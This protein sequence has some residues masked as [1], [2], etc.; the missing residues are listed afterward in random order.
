MSPSY[1]S[2]KR[3]GTHFSA[4][5]KS[6]KRLKAHCHR[7]SPWLLSSADLS[8]WQRLRVECCRAEHDFQPETLDIWVGTRPKPHLTCMFPH[9]LA[10]AA[11]VE[12]QTFKALHSHAR[13]TWFTAKNISQSE[14][15]AADDGVKQLLW[16]MLVI[17]LGHKWSRL[18]GIE[19]VSGINHKTRVSKWN[20]RSNMPPTLFHKL[21]NKRNG[22]TP[23]PKCDKDESAFRYVW[24][25]TF[26]LH[27]RHLPD[28][29]IHN[30]LETCLW[31][32]F[33]RLWTEYY[34]SKKLFYLLPN[35]FSAPPQ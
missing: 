14:Q 4:G 27:L 3:N 15:G 1:D 19:C 12:E 33:T 24:I 18:Q 30:N 6:T 34:R 22:F 29:L 10:P 9:G 26:T 20:S 8:V 25:F 17:W 5:L 21:F 35:G 11:F 28:A 16:L 7:V 13:V 32:W 31:Y 23:P 2:V